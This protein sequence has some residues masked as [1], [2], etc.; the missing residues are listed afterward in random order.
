MY[1]WFFSVTF[2]R[3]SIYF[4]KYVSPSFQDAREIKILFYIQ[5]LLLSTFKQN[6]KR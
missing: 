2:I 3:K 6:L 4:D 1:V 5:Y